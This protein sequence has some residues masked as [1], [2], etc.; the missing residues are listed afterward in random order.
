MGR[1]LPSARSSGSWRGGAGWLRQEG[2][3]LP[4]GP[5]RPP[6]LRGSFGL[7]ASP[8]SLFPISHFRSPRP[9]S[10][11]PACR[12]LGR[13]VMR[14]I[15]S[16]IG[17]RARRAMSAPSLRRSSWRFLPVSGGSCLFLAVPAG[18]GTVE[19]DWSPSAEAVPKPKYSSATVRNDHVN[20][21]YSHADSGRDGRERG[22]GGS[23]CAERT[24]S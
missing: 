12:V 22:R 17:R 6:R 4:G 10:A 2:P 15:D 19:P 21:L 3:P 1:V 11:P 8:T 9:L 14:Q 16:I 18:R 20:R 7:R 23:A 24:G 5:G 13:A